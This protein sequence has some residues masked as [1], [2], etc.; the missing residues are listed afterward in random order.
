MPVI[1]RNSSVDFKKDGI[2]RNYD[3]IFALIC[4]NMDITVEQRRFIYFIDTAYVMDTTKGGRYENL[5]PAYK[6]ILVSGLEQLKYADEQ[7]K[8]RKS[9]NSVID[10][11][12]LLVDRI[13]QQLSECE[14]NVERQ[15]EWFENLKNRPAQGFEEAIQRMLFVNQMFWQMDHRLTGLGAWDSIL[16]PYYEKDLASGVITKEEALDIIKDLYII[17]HDNYEFK[18]NVLMGDTGQIFVLGKSD[19]EGNYIYN[20]L[21]LLF[22]EAMKALQ[23][24]EPKCLLRVNSHTPREVVELALDAIVTG[25][26]APLLANDDVIIPKLIEFGITAEDACNYTTSA[27]WE[28]LIGGKS[29]SLNNQTVLN[30]VRALDNLLKR[31]NL[32]NITSFEELVTLYLKYLKRN[33]NAVKRVLSQIR[34]QYNPLLSVFLE[35][36]FE[37]EKDVSWGGAYYNNVGI[38][39]VGMGNL[40]NAFM[41]IKHLVFETGKYTLYDVKRM[42]ILNFE[43]DEETRELLL[44]EKSYYGTDEEEIIGLVNRITSFV[45][46]EIKDYRFYLGGKL[47]IGLSGSAYMDAAR[48]FGAS[49]DGRKYGEAFITHISN[50][51]NNGFTEVIQFASQLDY[52]NGN[53]NGNV[54]DLMVSPDFIH[55]NKE[56]FVD[57]LMACIYSGFFEMQMNVVSSNTLIE[58]RKSPEKFPNLVVRVWGFSS[59]FKDLPEEYKDIL[60][61]RAIKNERN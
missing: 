40:I 4:K 58:A 43:G 23:F 28:P 51:D 36:C 49:F 19:L 54:V 7:T 44:K 61:A 2:D 47:K 34:F 22:I 46:E 18:S 41:N 52:G 16:A 21:T 45:T 37:S 29:A 31:E 1:E 50:E 13:L 39:S 33:L 53:F 20:D 25:I 57:F 32:K 30:Y 26:G 6:K 56:K 15:I 60:I 27:C 3:E 59:Y 55:N 38:T 14:Y 5:T 35:G 11:M 42:V 8:F 48:G 10:G 12:A 17:L 9:Y 24:P